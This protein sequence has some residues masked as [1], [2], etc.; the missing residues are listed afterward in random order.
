MNIEKITT[1]RVHYDAAFYCDI[2]RNAGVWE[3]WLYKNGCGAALYMFG[4]PDAAEEDAVQMAAAN[5]DEYIKIF[6]DE[7]SSENE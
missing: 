7:F 5:I 4:L 6:N 1:I 2:T 3:V